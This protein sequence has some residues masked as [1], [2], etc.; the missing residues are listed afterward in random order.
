MKK[1]EKVDKEKF[2]KLKSIKWGCIGK[3]ALVIG[4]VT[5]GVIGTLEA[6]RAYN[7]IKASGVSEYQQNACEKFSD[8]N[9]A[10]YE[11]EVK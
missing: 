6:Q 3:V 9:T 10:W 11:C 1:V 5:I 2:S 7:N 8:K 4:L